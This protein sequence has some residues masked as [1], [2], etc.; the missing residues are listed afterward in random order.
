MRNNSQS[1]GKR[2]LAQAEKDL[3]WAKHPAAAEYQPEFSEKV[4]RW[5]ILDGFYIPTRYPNGLPD[6]IPA[7]VFTEE[8]A[9][10]A[11]KMAEDI[12]KWIE[13]FLS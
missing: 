12:V 4:R 3:H 7:D 9:Q 8:S 2:W 6:G 13:T 5:S 1:E 10:S 11:V